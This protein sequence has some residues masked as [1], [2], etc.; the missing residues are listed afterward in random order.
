MVPYAL[1]Q[2]VDFLKIKVLCLKEFNSEK[3]LDNDIN[4]FSKKTRTNL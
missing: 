4:V 2:K 1:G 3:F